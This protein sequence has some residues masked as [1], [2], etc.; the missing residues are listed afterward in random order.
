LIHKTELCHICIPT[1]PGTGLATGDR[2]ETNQKNQKAF[3]SHTGNLNA[4]LG[5]RGERGKGF[6]FAE[7]PA[8]GRKKRL[9]VFGKGCW[10]GIFVRLEG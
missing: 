1:D 4:N 5:L 2:S 7:A 8:D 9:F 3:I 10:E 6:A